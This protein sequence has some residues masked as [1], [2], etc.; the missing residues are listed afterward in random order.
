[1]FEGKVWC[2][3]QEIGGKLAHPPSFTLIVLVL[4]SRRCRVT[5]RWVRADTCFWRSLI[6]KCSSCVNTNTW[7]NQL[8]VCTWCEWH[9]TLYL[10]ISLSVPP[11]L[12]VS[13]ALLLSYCQI[14]CHVWMIKNQPSR[15]KMK[16]KHSCYT[17]KN[18]SDKV[19]IS[20]WALGTADLS[21]IK[22]VFFGKNL[23]TR[24]SSSP[25]AAYLFSQWYHHLFVSVH[26][27]SL[28]WGVLHC[29]CLSLFSMSLLSFFFC[30]SP[31]FA[32]LFKNLARNRDRRAPA[33]FLTHSSFLKSKPTEA[34][35]GYYL[36]CVSPL[37]HSASFAQGLWNSSLWN[38]TEGSRSVIRTGASWIWQ[39][40]VA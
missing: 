40:I 1:M 22:N 21:A 20:V 13:V 39:G 31:S 24:P 33:D 18:V 2:C 6:F 7:V 5:D 12:V 34:E 15:K 11:C 8:A 14:H 25:T 10:P 9:A 17:K 26:F 23:P 3:E 19:F 30:L 37:S 29:L 36:S 4:L 32:S 27:I 35:S 28:A 38:G 16:K